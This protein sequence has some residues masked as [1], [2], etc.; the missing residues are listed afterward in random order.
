MIFSFGYGYVSQF[1]KGQ[2]TS[3]SPEGKSQ[4]YYQ[5]GPFSQ[6]ILKAIQQAKG[7]LISIPPQNGQD[8][9][10]PFLEDSISSFRHLKWIGYLSSTSVYGDHKGAWVDEA[11][12]THPTSSYGKERLKAEH[13]W[14]KLSESKDLP[15]HIFRLA[16]I[17]GTERN[18]LE[19]LKV[20]KA[21]R[22]FKEN[23]LFS[24]THVIDIVQVLKASINNPNTGRIYN[25]ADSLPAPSHEV[26]EYGAQLLGIDPPP[27][28][29][30]ED[31]HLSEKGKSFYQDSKRVSNKR[32]L[33]ELVSSLK[34][35]SYK[36]GLKSLIEQNKT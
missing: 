28:I 33:S 4:F 17:Y 27:L 11:S 6:E 15:L 23:I 29:S 19:D 5:R 32:I 34:F 1:L 16:G 35:P 25:V 10:L 12:K 26:I 3:R 18:V 36:E 13:Q 22:I 9:L 21:Q 2:G 24:R 30:Y 20:G 31:A 8:I 14:L 7:L